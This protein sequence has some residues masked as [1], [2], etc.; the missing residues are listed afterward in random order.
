MNRR[1]FFRAL[2]ALAGGAVVLGGS[3]TRRGE[4][5]PAIKD[6]RWRDV[7]RNAM[8]T[9]RREGCPERVC[10]IVESSDLLH[11][12]IQEVYT[13][14]DGAT[15]QLVA[16]HC[17]RDMMFSRSGTFQRFTFQRMERSDMYGHVVDERGGHVALPLYRQFAVD[18]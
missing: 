3:G 11:D 14:P 6:G 16:V 15:L 5:L 9:Y 17:S 7:C 8:R 1:E 10:V 2:P 18:A 13:A 4:R 12:H